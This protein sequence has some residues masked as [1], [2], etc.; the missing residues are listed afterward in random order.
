MSS[1]VILSVETLSSGVSYA[2][3]TRFDKAETAVHDHLYSGLNF[4]G[5]YT[6]I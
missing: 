3:L 4:F 2:M 1:L 5:S 6:C